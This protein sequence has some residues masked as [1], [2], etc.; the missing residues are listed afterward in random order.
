MPVEGKIVQVAIAIVF[1]G[2]K[3]LIC[4][5]KADTVLG[6]YKEVP[7]E[8]MQRAERRRKPAKRA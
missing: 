6:G 7:E 5:R 2:G 1:D 8:Q 3:V 4:K